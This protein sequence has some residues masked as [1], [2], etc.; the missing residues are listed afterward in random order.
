[1]EKVADADLHHYLIRGP[2]RAAPR[3]MFPPLSNHA[4]TPPFTLKGFRA[5]V[6]FWPTRGNFR[7][8]LLGGLRVKDPAVVSA[9]AIKWRGSYFAAAFFEHFVQYCGIFRRQDR[10][11]GRWAPLFSDLSYK[12]TPAWQKPEIREEYIGAV[13]A[14]FEVRLPRHHTPPPP[15]PPSSAFLNIL[16]KTLRMRLTV[17]RPCRE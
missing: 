12:D 8:H 2:Q 15:S 9:L 7:V 1:M 17:K 13:G 10:Y 14:F 3:R 6:S 4:G 5:W 16:S 11:S